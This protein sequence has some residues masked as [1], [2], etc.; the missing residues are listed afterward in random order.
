L[1]QTTCAN[2]ITVSADYVFIGCADG[3]VRI[4]SP[5]TLHYVTS[6]PRPHYLG[7]DIAAAVD[8]AYA[9]TTQTGSKDF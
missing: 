9:H 3:I 6:L 1:W 8:A 4:F 2:S 7:V 5:H